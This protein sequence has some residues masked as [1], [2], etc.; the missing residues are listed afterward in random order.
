[1]LGLP[2]DGKPWAEAWYG[3]HPSAPSTYEDGTSVELEL[4]FLLKILSANIPLSIQAHPAKQDAIRLHAEGKLPDANHK[5]ETI[6]ALEGGMEAR[7]GVRSAEVFDQ[8]ID[9]LAIQGLKR[10]WKGGVVSHSPEQL[11]TELL[12]MDYASQAELVSKLCLAVENPVFR[13]EFPMDQYWTNECARVFTPDGHNPHDIGVAI[14]LFMNYV[15]L[16]EGEGL[17][18]PANELHAYLRGTGIEIMAS[19]DNVLR[20]GLTPKPL[21]VEELIQLQCFRPTEARV[22]E[23]GTRVFSQQDTHDYRLEVV[24]GGRVATV[25]D[26]PTILLAL[27][28]CILTHPDEYIIASPGSAWLYDGSSS[29]QVSVQ[30]DSAFIASIAH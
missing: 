18:M 3:S 22:A 1:M 20:A 24:E 6:V 19:S 23:P 10:L 9:R 12:T 5:P 28:K 30:E 17:H 8:I 2:V 26:R 15:R 14:Q 4:P 29:E 21:A 13:A 7:A 16:T 25:L 27:G 11:L